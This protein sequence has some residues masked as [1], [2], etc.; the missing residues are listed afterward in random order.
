MESNKNFILGVF[1]DEDVLMDACGNVR[2]KG[3][4][5]SRS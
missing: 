2:E 3:V 1:T 5:C 4:P